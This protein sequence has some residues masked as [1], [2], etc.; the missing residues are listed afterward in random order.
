MSRAK[1][2]RLITDDE[3]QDLV[4]SNFGK[5]D[6]LEVQQQ[7]IK[8]QRKQEESGKET[9][10][11]S[12]GKL[13]DDQKWLLY[14][15]ALHRMIDATKINDKTPLK[16]QIDNLTSDLSLSSN[17]AAPP[18]AAAATAVS[19]AAASGNQASTSTYS[20][21]SWIPKAQHASAIN[22]KHCLDRSSAM[23]LK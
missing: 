18:T 19:N 5:A 20:I 3:Y 1:K 4:N 14:Q 10:N 7:Q 16:V 9:A 21:F 2:M 22:I 8:Q 11:N 12:Y 17:A 13:G 6:P 15:Q 23:M